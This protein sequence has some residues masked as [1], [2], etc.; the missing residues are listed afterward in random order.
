MK[1]HFIGICGAGMS[2]VAKFLTEKG[3]TVTG[4]DEGF[5]PPISDYLVENRISY[6]TP[7]SPTNIPA[8]ADVIVIGKHAKLVP[9]ENEEVKAAFNSGK[10]ILSFAQVLEQLSQDKERIVV[11]G[12]FGKST[13]TSLLSWC[14]EHAGRDPSYFI[15]ALP[16]TPNTNAHLGKGKE[17]ILEGDEYPSSNW[18]K[19]SKFMFFHPKHLLVTALAHDHVNVFPTHEDYLSPFINLINGLPAEGKL[20]MCIDDKTV[21]SKIKSFP[22]EIVTY[23]LEEGTYH[24]ENIVFGITTTFDLVRNGSVLT[25]LSTSLLGKHN[26]QNIVGVSALL[27]E[28]YK[29]TKE[30][31]ASGIQT[32]KGI[33]RRLDKKSGMTSIP[34]YEGFGS[35]VDK[36]RSAIEAI[37][38]HFSTKRLV[39]IFEPHA[40]SWRNRTTIHWYD[41][42]FEGVGHVFLYK[43]PD[44]GSA[45]H[46][47]L[48]LDEIKERIEAANTSVTSFEN[49]SIGLT[50][51]IEYTKSEDVILILSSGGMNGFIPQIILALEEKF[52]A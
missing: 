28:T 15:G 16:L 39:V 26:I 46:D 3:E 33:T 25:S 11:V 37:K 2:A 18:D 41:S 17:F 52:P 44:H 21:R 45:T 34:I 51:L 49:D 4:S 19:T 24:V 36:A 12:S 31:L 38:L 32:F 1:Y 8:D 30:Q 14:L 20:I 40:F 7:F 50:K 43:P 48:S 9:E 47:Q 6:T 35:S 5:Y 29:I 42:V 23:G 13:C 27:L 22:H 10:P